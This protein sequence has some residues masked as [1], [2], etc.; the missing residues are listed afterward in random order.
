MATGADCYY[1]DDNGNYVWVWCEEKHNCICIRSGNLNPLTCMPEWLGS[2]PQNS[3]YEPLAQAAVLAAAL[4]HEACHVE[5]ASLKMHGSTGLYDDYCAF[6]LNEIKCHC[7]E[8][9]LLDCIIASTPDSIAK[10]QIKAR[11]RS[12]DLAKFAYYA[13]AFFYGCL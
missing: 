7:M 11:R 1:L 10:D 6:V 8:L 2:T 12:V 13:E 3:L 5:T 4:A 9:D